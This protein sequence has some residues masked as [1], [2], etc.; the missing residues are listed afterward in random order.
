MR[1]GLCDAQHCELRD[2]NKF[3]DEQRWVRKMLDALLPAELAQSDDVQAFNNYIADT[4]SLTPTILGLDTGKLVA[5]YQARTLRAAVHLAMFQAVLTSAEG[6]V[7]PHEAP[8][9]DTEA[10]DRH[11]AAHRGMRRFDQD[12]VYRLWMLGRSIEYISRFVDLPE[13][14]I[15]RLIEEV[16]VLRLWQDGLNLIEISGKLQ[17]P[18]EEV[19]RWIPAAER[20]Q[21]EV[22]AAVVSSGVATQLGHHEVG[23]PQ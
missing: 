15:V 21:R 19:A 13:D 10:R 14:T 8:S 18:V 16:R 11:L 17:L 12:R 22:K 20:H 6:K 5:G 9:S 7:R 23:E 1:D 3:H 4:G 2:P